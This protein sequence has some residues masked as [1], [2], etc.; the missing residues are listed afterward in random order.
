[1]RLTFVAFKT[2]GCSLLV[3]RVLKLIKKKFKPHQRVNS[4][5]FRFQPLYLA[6]LAVPSFEKLPPLYVLSFF[7]SLSTAVLVPTDLVRGLQRLSGGMARWRKLGWSAS[8]LRCDTTLINGQTFGWRQ[9][10]APAKTGAAA[11]LKSLPK[12]SAKRAAKT[13]RVECDS[14]LLKEWTGV[15]EGHVISLRQE[16][17]DTLVCEHY[18]GTSTPSVLDE[19]LQD[20]FSLRAGVPPLSELYQQWSEKDPHFAALG[21]HLPGLRILR[22]DP[23]ECLFSFLCSSNNHI[24]RITKMLEALRVNY[25][26]FLCKHQGDSSSCVGISLVSFFVLIGSEYFSFP[27][28]EA[29]ATKAT[30]ERLRQLGFGYRAKFVVQAA[31]QVH[32]NGTVTLA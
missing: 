16:K 4:A 18:P 17:K 29:L 26:T 20:Y 27:T 13:K 14:N 9:A 7:F 22:Q 3:V 1:M 8:V 12:G 2:V 19:K 15:V 10:H 31:K 23:V 28:V 21:A 25:G 6:F 5:F 32:D 30:E 11:T 24:S